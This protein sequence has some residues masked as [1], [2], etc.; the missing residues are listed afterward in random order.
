MSRSAQ[1]LWTFLCGFSF[2]AALDMFRQDR[3]GLEGYIALLRL[4]WLDI[5]PGWGFG[6]M[7]LNL[8]VA[9]YIWVGYGKKQ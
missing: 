8:L 3:L 7:V 1:L 2:H 5:S 6:L 4:H 9:W